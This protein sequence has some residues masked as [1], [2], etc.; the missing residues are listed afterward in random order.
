MR[1]TA[2]VF[3]LL[4][5]AASP[6]LADDPPTSEVSESSRSSDAASPDVSIAVGAR[7]SNF[8]AGGAVELRLRTASEI[9]V[10]VDAS[11]GRDWDVFVGGH[12]A[13]DARRFDVGTSLLAPVWRRDDVT[14]SIGARAYLRRLASATSTSNLAPTSSWAA[15]LDLALLLHAPIRERGML[16]VGAVVP[17]GFEVSPEFHADTTGSGGAL[18]SL[19]GAV[20]LSDHLALTVDVDAG[21]AFGAN[22]DGM[23]LLARG[24]VA[25]RFQPGARRW[26]RF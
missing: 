13:H 18:L 20:A 26:L 22:G 15:G 2:S 19:G 10:G 24:T 23:K 17:I 5:L 3:L 21:G 4:L 25:L 11:A 1:T 8:G 9:Q 14:M 12:A 16:R 6:A 7:V